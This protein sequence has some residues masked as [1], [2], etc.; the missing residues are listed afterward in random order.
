MKTGI[1]YESKKVLLIGGGGTIG[2]YV[3]EE[4]LKKGSSVDIICLE[5]YVSDNPKLRYFKNN[6]TLD[7][8]KG[9]LADKHYNGIL[10]F[11]H[12]D[13]PEDYIDF[14]MQIAPKT[15]H[16]IFFSSI[17]AIGDAQHPITETAPR[18]L[19]LIDSGEFTDKDFIEKDAYSL[20]KSRC[21]RYLNSVSKYRNFTI[22]RPMI[23]TSEKRFDIVIDT[24][25]SPIEFAKS[26]EIMYQPDVCRDKVAGL[27]WAGNTGKMIA[28]LLFKE[29]CMGQTYMLST[30]H[31]MTWEDVANV[32][33]KLIGLKVEW[34]PV[35]EYKV[36]RNKGG[37][38]IMYDRNYDR[39]VDNT[40]ILEATGLTAN[41]FTPFEDGI[42][43][44]LKKVGAI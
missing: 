20:S 29:E 1:D 35:E 43:Q 25:Q 5:D 2:S 9:F 22:V 24:F 28:D 33:T 15:D 34:V 6:V 32:Y 19:D 13:V 44:E 40:K 18:I 23:S 11:I 12:H 3:A 7:Y 42:K 27:E 21:E 8:L 30:G 31:R 26:G 16:E 38:G 41:D 17:R 39:A 37:W 36:K 14:H 4:L 10:D